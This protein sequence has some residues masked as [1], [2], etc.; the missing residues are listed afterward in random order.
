MS[1]KIT[2]TELR[3]QCK[4]RGLKGSVLKKEEL[5]KLLSSKSESIF[6]RVC[7]SGSNQY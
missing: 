5:I 2:L 6:N 3:Q 4:D 1:K 7:K